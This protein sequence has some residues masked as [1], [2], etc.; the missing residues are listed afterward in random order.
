MLVLVAKLKHG[1]VV[2]SNRLVTSPCAVVTDSYAWTGNMERLMAAQNN[3]E[4]N[5]VLDF[6]RTAKRTFEINPKHPLIEGLLQK[7]DEVEG[8][9]DAAVELKE[10]V[11]VLW[12]TALVKSGFAVKDVNACVAVL[13]F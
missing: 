2:I 1:A 3:R 11:G 6:I 10:T 13:C 12:D 7:V 4:S 5:M 8:D 9:P